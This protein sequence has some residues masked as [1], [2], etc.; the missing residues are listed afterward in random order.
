VASFF[1]TIT[2]LILMSWSHP[3]GSLCLSGENP[4]PLRTVRALTDFV[5]KAQ[6]AGRLAR[7]DADVFARA[8]LGA[9]HNF[10]FFE[11]VFK[12]AGPHASEDSFVRG[13]VELLLHGA[14]APRGSRKVAP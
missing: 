8:F 1:R 11:I 12:E 10:V 9:I 4:A 6:A 3:A 7:G 13:L 2:P 14:K 5:R